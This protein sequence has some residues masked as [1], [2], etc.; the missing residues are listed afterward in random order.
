MKECIL[1]LGKAGKF[2]TKENQRKEDARSTN[3]WSSES[4]T[5]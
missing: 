2:A 4:V 1:G 5:T 3:I